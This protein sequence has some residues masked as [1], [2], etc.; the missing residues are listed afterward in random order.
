MDSNHINLYNKLLALVLG[1]YRV[2]HAEV[3]GTEQEGEGRMGTGTGTG[4]EMAD[5]CGWNRTRNGGRERQAQ[6]GQAA[7]GKDEK[8][9]LVGDVQHY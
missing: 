8:S 3:N 7:E 5:R 2:P 9:M 6:A 4:T 1:R